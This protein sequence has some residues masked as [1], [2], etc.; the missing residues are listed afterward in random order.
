[1]K[2]LKT[3]I[4]VQNAVF[5]TPFSVKGFETFPLPPYSTVIGLLYTALGRKYKGEKF[6]ISV[7]GDYEVLF[8][9]YL[10]FKKYNKKDKKL[11]RKPLEVPFL[12]NFSLTC[13][14]L[15]NEELLKQFEETLKKPKTFLGLGALEIPAKVKSVK[16]LNAEWK[17]L[18]KKQKL[19]KN[20]YIPVYLTENLKLSLPYRTT[21][22]RYA[23]IEFW[24]PSFIKQKEPYRDYYFEE[25][26]YV[27]KNY[28]LKSGSRVLTD[29][30]GDFIF[31]TE[32]H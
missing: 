6:R 24:I 7:Q 11:E 31:P 14:I 32:E 5:K 30:E 29:E 25:V 10:I 12:Y 4:F 16:I 3:E 21:Y 17:E 26:L 2:V 28:E 20:A 18:D 1:M 9:D 15:G 19:E 13:H 27:T 22:K 23:G 8:R